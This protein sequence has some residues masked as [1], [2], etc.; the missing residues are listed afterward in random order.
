MTEA[1]FVYITAANN[2][3]ARRISAHLIESSLAACVATLPGITS[4]YRW[5]G[6]VQE[7]REVALF[8]KTTQNRVPALIEAVKNLHSYE[9]PC[10]VS[11][12]IDDGFPP[13]LKWIADQ[14]V[15]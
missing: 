13:F 1:R 15:A 6:K 3:E 14:Q 10:I 2:D 7:S 11:L 8:A 4:H 12:P 9:C 5:E